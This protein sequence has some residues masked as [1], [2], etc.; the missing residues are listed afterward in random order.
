MAD[1]DTNANVKAAQ[2]LAS[3]E[4]GNTKSGNDGSVLPSASQTGTESQFF[5]LE[6]GLNSVGKKVSPNVTELRSGRADADWRLRASLGS[7][8]KDLYTGIMAPLISTDGVIF[9]YTPQIQINYRANYGKKTLTHANYPAFFYQGSEVSDVQINATFTAQSS[10]EASYLMAVIH[11]FKVT[12]KM[13][14]GQDGNKN[15][16]PPPLIFL[17]GFGDG[18]F[19]NVA[20]VNNQLNYNL[21]SDV[22]YIRTATGGSATGGSDTGNPFQIQNAISSVKG[23]FNQGIS[24]LLGAGVNKNVARLG[25]LA[26]NLLGVNNPFG[27]VTD[28][29]GSI[30]GGF[31]GGSP[32]LSQLGANYVPT[33]IELAIT[34]YPIVSRAKQT[35]EFSLKEFAAGNLKGHW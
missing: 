7:G 22:D 5:Q 2:F 29:V 32:S 8:A 21:P 26:S 4:A 23:G 12:T 19:D 27:G 13:Y 10:E 25:G 16:M 28:R 11:F 24:R 20:C 1:V 31:N 14:Y 35:N 34:L 9:P 30:L 3:K 6:A 17:N 18:Q 33:V 15:G